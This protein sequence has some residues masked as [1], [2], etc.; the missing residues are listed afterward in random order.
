MVSAVGQHVAA[1]S[2]L[3]RIRFCVSRP[4]RVEAFQRQIDA[5]S[6]D[7]SA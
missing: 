1:G 6:G 2:Q 5:L 4:E 7:T 3:E